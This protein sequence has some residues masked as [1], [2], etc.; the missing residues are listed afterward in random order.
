MIE[1]NVHINQQPLGVLSSNLADG[2]FAFQYHGNEKSE[3]TTGFALSPRLPS[4]LSQTIPTREHSHEVKVFLKTSCQKD[5]AKTSL[6][7][8]IGLASKTS[9]FRAGM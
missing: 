4:T 5:K 6:R 3:R 8:F 9:Q 1:L 7:Y 2:L